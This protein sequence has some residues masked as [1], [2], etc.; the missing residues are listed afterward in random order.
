[1]SKGLEY[2]IVVPIGLMNRISKKDYFIPIQNDTEGHLLPVIDESSDLFQNFQKEIDAEKMR[3]LY[4]AITR[5]K[6]RLYLPIAFEEKGLKDISEGEYSP[7]ELFL[8]NMEIQDSFPKWLDQHGDNFSYEFI[9]APE[10]T[11]PFIFNSEV[12]ELQPPQKISINSTN[13]KVQ[14]FSSIAKKHDVLHLVDEPPHDFLN[15]MKTPFTIPSGREIGLLLHSI[16]ELISYRSVKQSNVCFD[17]EDLVRPYVQHTAF[18]EWVPTISEIIF[19]ALKRPLK[20]RHGTVTLCEI[21]DESRYHEIEFL[22]PHSEGLLKGII[23]LVFEWEGYYYLVDWK[24]NW[25]GKSIYDYQSESL[26]RVMKVHEYDLQEEIYREALKRY[27]KAF[28]QR[29]FESCF[30]GSYYLF[31]R[32]MGMESNSG[33]Y[34]PDS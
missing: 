10:K 24:S 2:D 26:E 33:V 5:A 12:T 32:G 18:S 3:Q 29:P 25:L 34:T 7:W 6:H 20:T 27:L 30:G 31:L 11:T 22:Y 1:M 14:S 28:D 13:Q 4:V 21:P 16:L 19:T 17:I 23:D 9:D 8:L 15:E